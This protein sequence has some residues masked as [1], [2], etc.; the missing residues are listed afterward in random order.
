MNQLDVLT[1]LPEAPI[2]RLGQQI[3][4]LEFDI[5]GSIGGGQTV[6]QRI[7]EQRSDDTFYYFIRNELPAQARPHN[8][9]ALEFVEAWA[10][11]GLRVAS[12]LQSMVG[13]YVLCRN[14]A[15]SVRHAGGPSAFD[16]VD[17]PDFRPIGAFVRPAFADEDI[18]VGGVAL[19]MHGTLSDAFRGGWASDSGEQRVLAELRVRERLQYRVADIRYAI[20]ERYATRWRRIGSQRVNLLDPLCMVPYVVPLAAPPG[21]APDL[22]FLGRR[23]KW[24]GPDLFLDIAWCLDPASYG[25]M[26][27]F[28][29]D[30]PNR[31]GVGSS[32]TMNAMARLRHLR[33]EILAGITRSEIM[34]I[35]G[36]RNLLLLPSRYDTFNLTALEAIMAGCPT[37]VSRRAG[38]ADWLTEQLPELPWVTIDIDCSRQAAATVAAVLAD[39]DRHREALLESLERRNIRSA[40]ATFREIYRPADD[41]DLQARQTAIELATSLAGAIEANEGFRQSLARV[42]KLYVSPRIRATRRALRPLKRVWQQLPEGT[43]QGVHNTRQA[44]A[45][46]LTIVGRGTRHPYSRRLIA[47]QVRDSSGLS[48]RAFSQVIAARTASEVHRRILAERPRSAKDVDAKLRWLSSLVADRLIDRVTLFREMAQLERRRGNHMIAAT[49]LLRTMRWLGRDERGDLPYVAACLRDLGFSG[50]AET[51][52]AIFGAESDARSSCLALM[53]DALERNRTKLELALAVREDFR[54]PI[55]PRVSVIASL[56]NAADKLPTLLTMLANQSLARSGGLEVVLVDSNSPSDEFGA[57][58]AFLSARPLSVLYLRSAQR[59]TIQA[60]WNRGIHQSRA[61]YLAFLG[62]DEGLHPDALSTL[63]RQLDENPE[64]DWAMADSVVTNVDREGVYDSDVMPYDRTGYRQ[65]LVYLDTTYL[66]WVGGLYRRSLHDRFGWYDETYRAAGDTEFKNRLLP[67]IRSMH[68]PQLLGVFNN[69]PEE[70]T[71]ASPRAELEDLRAWYL[72]RTA[73]GMEYAFGHRPVT[74]AIELFKTSLRYRKAFCGHISSDFDLAHSVAEY[75]A[76][77]PEGGAIGANALRAMD[78]TRRIMRSLEIWQ[79]PVRR[80]PGRVRD[81]AWMFG[82]LRRLRHL[83]E[84]HR[85]EFSL[86]D[87]P[88]YEAFNDNR[89]EQHWWSWSTP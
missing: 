1:V 55:Q 10:G 86:A 43:R 40:E 72:W 15:A 25:E 32:P 52:E 30:G 26:K 54:A 8:A 82:R 42:R 22:T 6:Y 7:I 79:Q 61:P 74:E 37:I 73:A 18:R 56:Y 28:G 9:V 69:Y 35:Y 19:A 29:P 3:L 27:F 34:E 57:L 63:A 13:D 58:Q 60:A 5:F 41:I 83:A 78:E 81:A 2:H 12:G 67:F 53:H 70:R 31:L 62:A 50:E 89:Y 44:I 24:K 77:R 85:N 46:A 48:Q 17:V 49:Y 23:E 33:P 45:M 64:V 59:E 75:L 68:V 11:R 47:Q 16:V 20:S 14:F 84:S 39:Y 36:S 88:S 66:S 4:I 76:E 51:A 80:D 65:D 38:V 71:T 87:V 21:G